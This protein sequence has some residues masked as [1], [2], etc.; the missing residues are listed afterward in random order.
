MVG[1]LDVR[2]HIHVALVTRSSSPF[3]LSATP[4]CETAPFIAE[5]SKAEDVNGN[6]EIRKAPAYHKDTLRTP[7]TNKHWNKTNVFSK[8]DGIQ[9]P[10]TPAQQKPL[11]TLQ[12]IG[13]PQTLH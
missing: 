8:N 1:N 3:F 2:P 7:S 5:K 13:E 11:V 12:D 10:S 4:N 9:T 6:G